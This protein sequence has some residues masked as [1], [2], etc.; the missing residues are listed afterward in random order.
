M[1]PAIEE[2]NRTEHE[3][4]ALLFNPATVVALNSFMPSVQTAALSLAVQANAAP[5]HA[6]ESDVAQQSCASCAISLSEICL[7][8]QPPR[9]PGQ[10]QVAP[11][12]S[13][14]RT[15]D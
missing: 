15:S 12:S 7:F 14:D 6:K 10:G 8:T 3:R 9:A 1:G 11:A 4:V 13:A 5:V 2:G